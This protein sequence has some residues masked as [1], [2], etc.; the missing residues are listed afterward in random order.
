MERGE[1]RLPG[2][3]VCGL[4]CNHQHWRIDVAVGDGWH[5]GCIDNTKAGDAVYPEG[6]VGDAVAIGSHLAAAAGVVCALEFVS[7]K[8]QDGFI[9]L[10]LRAR[11]ELGTS[12]G[13]EG[14]LT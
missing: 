1:R 6:W 12:E 13:F 4:L 2:N 3:N 9:G 5:H 11:S 7:D 8:I 10:H 14:W